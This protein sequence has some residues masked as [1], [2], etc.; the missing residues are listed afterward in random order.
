MNGFFLAAAYLTQNFKRMKA[1]EYQFARQTSMANVM[2]AIVSGRE[3]LYKV[4]LPEGWTTAQLVER[5]NSRAELAG[6]ISEDLPEGGLLPAT[7]GF[8]RGAER[9]AVINAMREAQDKLLAELWSKRASDLPLETKEQAL[10][11]ASIVEKETGV[12][13]ERPRVAAV[14]LNRLKK[15]MR[16]QSDPTIVY[17]ITLGKRKLDRPILQEDIE[18]KSPYNTY[19]ISGLPP[20]PIANPGRDAILAVLNPIDTGE[21]YFVADGTGGHVFA[22]SLEEHNRNVQKW[23]TIERAESAEAQ[24]ADAADL[25]SGS[26]DAVAV[27]AEQTPQ[28]PLASVES[29]E[30]GTPEAAPIADSPS[31]SLASAETSPGS[32]NPDVLKPGSVVEVAGKLIPIPAPR[33]KLQ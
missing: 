8:R 33:P 28:A 24:P 9:Q 18:T 17:G 30:P 3:Y 22:K 11:L 6:T 23:R 15:Q 20:T 27:S 32:A 5:L 1:G 7:Y 12:P 2:D 13:E 29:T 4:T 19:Q 21:L 16:L 31:D 14:F 25:A 10:I 26:G